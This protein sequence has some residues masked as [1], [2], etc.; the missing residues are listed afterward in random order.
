MDELAN[1]YLNIKCMF[2]SIGDN[3]LFSYLA[4]PRSNP[5]P[6]NLRPRPIL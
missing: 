1:Q 2:K 6:C 3:G 5:K 4:I